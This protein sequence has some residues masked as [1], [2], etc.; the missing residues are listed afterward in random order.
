[1]RQTNKARI[2]FSLS[3][4]RDSGRVRVFAQIAA[5]PLRA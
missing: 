1:M 2:K 4:K 5:V 3:G